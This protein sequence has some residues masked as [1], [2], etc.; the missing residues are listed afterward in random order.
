LSFFSEIKSDSALFFK[1]QQ[2]IFWRK[3]T[4][5]ATTIKYILPFFFVSNKQYVK[6]TKNA[7]SF[8]KHEEKTL[9]FL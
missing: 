1:I 7:R 8:K 9:A 4:T 3:P 5:I 6:K 2:C